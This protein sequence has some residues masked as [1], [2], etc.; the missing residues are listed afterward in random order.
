IEVNPA[1]C[2][3]LGYSAEELCGTTGEELTHADDREATRAGTAALLA[4]EIG[5]FTLDKRYVRRDGSV[6]CCPPTVTGIR[7]ADGQVQQLV[8][9]IEQTGAEEARNRLAAVVESSDDAVISKTLEG[10]I[11]SWNQ[12][13]E[14]I[15]GYT[16]AE[17][18]G[19]PVTILIPPDH[20]D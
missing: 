20:L 19:K 11:T 3:L 2:E 12:A 10:V 6:I 15:F 7:A 8:G 5:E 16:A 1:L 9:V 4:G 13:A 14:R 18:I 17:A